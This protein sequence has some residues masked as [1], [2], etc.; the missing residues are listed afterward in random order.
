MSILFSGKTN[1]GGH[2]LVDMMHVA[3]VVFRPKSAYL[4]FFADP[5][6]VFVHENARLWDI[7]EKVEADGSQLFASITST[8]FVNTIGKAAIRAT[9][10]K[11]GMLRVS[12]MC[13]DTNT[14]WRL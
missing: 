11:G 10:D 3:A 5:S 1:C 14:G 9:I 12:G 13:I 2:A 7:M 4:H 6:V 8:V